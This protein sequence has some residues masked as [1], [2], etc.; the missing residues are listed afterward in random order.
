M[1]KISKPKLESAVKLTPLKMNSIHFGGA[2]SA[3]H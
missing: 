1:K 2:M 3:P